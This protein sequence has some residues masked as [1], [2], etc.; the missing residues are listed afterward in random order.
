MSSKS[1]DR[2]AYPSDVSDEEW[3][4]CAA[5]RRL[6]TQHAPQRDHELR[7]VF[8]ALRYFVRTGLPMANAPKRPSALDCGLPANSTVVPSRM[9]RGD[10]A[11][12]CAG[13]C[14]CCLSV[15]KN[16]VE[17]CST[18]AHFSRLPESGARAGY[19]GYKRKKGSKV[20]IA[21]DTLGHLLALKVTAANEQERAQVGDL[22][23]A[24]QMATQDS[25]QISYVDQGYT[26][27]RTRHPSREARY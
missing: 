4:F 19:D 12:I 26:G 5:S 14:E 9:L 22:A 18:A 2:R 7:E 11:R 16:Q 20:H 8:N 27:R 15:M 25:V 3:E 1:R 21:V 13:L 17:V 6:M 24:I 10:G 23:A